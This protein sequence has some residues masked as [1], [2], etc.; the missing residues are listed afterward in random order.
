[1]I[2]V[3]RQKL[4]T[5]SI[6]HTYPIGGSA[7][8]SPWSFL[9]PPPPPRQSTAP[10]GCRPTKSARRSPKRIHSM[11]QMRACFSKPSG[12]PNSGHNPSLHRYTGKGNIL[13]LPP[14]NKEYLSQRHGPSVGRH[15]KARRIKNGIFN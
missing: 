5:I 6:P 15:T 14:Q 9:P 12:C 11:P 4:P 10:A 7:P 1:M 13:S 3:M 8:C 2:C